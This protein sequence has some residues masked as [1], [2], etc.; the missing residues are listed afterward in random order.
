MQTEYL[1]ETIDTHTAGEPTRIV[2]SGFQWDDQYD[3]ALEYQR[4]FE[5]QFDWI[6]ELL[7][8]EPRGH[9][10][11]FGAVPVP[12]SNADIGVFFMDNSEYKDMCGH[13][14]IGLVTAFIETN[15]LPSRD[16][17]EIETPAG[18][19]NARPTVEDGR[20][21]SVAVENVDSYVYDRVTIDL[22]PVGE[23][24][25]DIVYAGNFFALVDGTDLGIDVSTDW[26]SELVEY[27]MQ[28][29]QQINTE[30]TIT[31]PVTEEPDEIKLTEIYQPE[32]GV[33]RN[34][35]VFG[36]G[37]VD[38][39]P[40]GTG[41]C[42]KMAFLHSTDELDADEAYPYQSILGT[43]FTGRIRDTKSRGSRTVISPEIEGSAHVIS[44]NTYF[45]DPSDPLDG[46]SIEQ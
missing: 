41:T 5:D 22:E 15:Q 40:C 32:R 20:V 11:M 17:I 19:V 16:L 4:R 43:K 38:R 39:S 35:T 36:N 3:S 6:R 26:T 45:V 21:V 29:K 12:S 14:T 13:G 1:F 46:F 28:I 2:T 8:K 42:A 34:V 24:D 33:D 31:N 9:D 18:I 27:G 37:Q 30:M 7:M 10:D 44:K 25:V 23:V